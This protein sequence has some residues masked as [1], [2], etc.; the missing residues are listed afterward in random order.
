LLRSSAC[1][2]YS[3]TLIRRSEFAIFHA[4]F[5]DSACERRLPHALGCAP[6]DAFDQHRKLR[7]RQCDRTVVTRIIGQAKRPGDRL[8]NKQSHCRPRTGSQHRCFLPRKANSD[9]E[10]S[11]FSVS[12]T[13]WQA[14]HALAHVGVAERQVNFYAAGT[15]I[16]CNS[17]LKRAL[18]RHWIAA[19]GSKDTRPSGRSTAIIP[20]E[21][22][23]DTQNAAAL[24]HRQERREQASRVSF[25]PRRTLLASG[26]R[27]PD[28]PCLRATPETSL[29]AARFLSRSRASVRR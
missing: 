5:C 21:L 26:T 27:A 4:G 11:F 23:Q 3:N 29:P 8:V 10:R 20:R 22:A 9:R 14:V 24:C 15:I 18:E 13:A 1:P 12:C 25:A 6:V 17:P 2:I 19:G 16:I 28:D 7:R